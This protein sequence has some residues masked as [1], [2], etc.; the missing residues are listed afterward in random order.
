MF[1]Y[2]L[3]EKLILQ[4]S[5]KY[6]VLGPLLHYSTADWK[7]QKSNPWQHRPLGKQ[8]PNPGMGP[9]LSKVTILVPAGLK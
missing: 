1:Q 3:F 9:V 4:K 5:S 7:E 8:E 6:D 2:F